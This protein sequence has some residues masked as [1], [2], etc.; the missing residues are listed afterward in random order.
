MRNQPRP[1]NVAEPHG[2]THAL[3]LPAADRAFRA[4]VKPRRAGGDGHQIVNGRFAPVR[5]VQFA[6][7]ED[8]VGSNYL[9]ANPDLWEAV[10]ESD[11]GAHYATTGRAQNRPYR[12]PFVLNFYK[13]LYLSASQ[14]RT[15]K[16]MEKDWRAA[17]DRYGSLHEVLF[18]AGFRPPNWLNYF[19]PD[20]YISY[21]YLWHSVRNATQALV[22]FITIGV[23][24]L[25]AISADLEFESAFVRATLGAPEGLDDAAL[26]KHWVEH[27]LGP[28]MRSQTFPPNETEMLRRLNLHLSFVPAS[29]DWRRYLAERPGIEGDVHDRWSAIEHFANAGVLQPHPLPLPIRLAEPLLRAAADRFAERNEFANGHAAYE[30]YLLCPNATGRGIQHAG[31]LALREGKFTR[32]LLLYNRVRTLGH[33]N[34]WTYVNGAACALEI[35]EFETARE[36]IF[37][38]LEDF[39]R[40][41]RLQKS[42]MDLQNSIFNLAVTRHVEILRAGGESTFAADVQEIYRSFQEC[43]AIQYGGEAALRRPGAAAKLVVAVLAN[44]DLAQCTYY[45][46]S[47]KLEHLTTAGV[48]IRVFPLGEEQKFLSAAATADVAIFYRIAA[49]AVTLQCAAYC[50]LINLPAIY[51]IDDLVFD[52][53]HF[54]DTHESYAGAISAEKHF[55]LRCGVALVRS[56]IAICDYGI[57]STDALRSEL[58]KLV[59]TGK[60]IVHRNLLSQEL[61][62]TASLGPK[63][64]TGSSVTIFYGSGTLAHGRDFHD[65][66]EPALFRLMTENLEVRFMACGHVD[67]TALETAFPSRVALVDFL[68][69]RDT[70]LKL[71]SGADINIAVL[72]ANRFNDCKSEIKWLEA[73]AFGIPSVVSDVAVYRENLRP[74]E[75]LLLAAADPA[76]WYKA[77]R[78]LVVGPALRAEIGARAR[79]RALELYEPKQAAKRLAASLGELAAQPAAASGQRRRRILIVNVFFPPQAI[80]GA[81]RIVA[82]QVADMCE[83]Y[84]GQYEVAVFCGN[85]EEAPPYEMTAYAWNGVPVYSVNTPLR[86]GND[87]SYADPEIRPAFESVLARFKPDLVHF[88][89]IQRLTTVMIDALQSRAIPFVVTVHDAWWISDHQFLID[90]RDR[91]ELPWERPATNS[92]SAVRLRML[93]AKLTQAQAVLAVSESF[94]ALYRRAGIPHVRALVNGMTGLPPLENAK[95]ERGKLRI[96]HF[97]GMGYIKGAFLLKRALSRGHFPDIE[98]VVVDLAKSY[99]EE[100]HEIWGATAVKIIG[101]VPQDKIGW[102]YG[103]IDVLIAPSVWPESFGLCVREAVTYGKWI[104]VSDRGALPEAV[105]PGVN[106][107]VVDLND[108]QALPA[109]LVKLQAQMPRFLQLPAAA[110]HIT[111][112]RENTTTLCGIFSEILAG[113]PVAKPKRRP[114]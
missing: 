27:M 57:A 77:L 112:M 13:E 37:E 67:V 104:V 84:A 41:A 45:R 30:R 64:F 54:P 47:Q 53:R 103:Q 93:A 114:H 5:Q 2:K 63:V 105:L 51:E 99:G 80:G 1:R 88:H 65:L 32:A 9:I 76:A 79:A 108:P 21:N 68:P 95:R 29:F 18:R 73:A 58:A 91:L 11:A 26:Y 12:L 89:A 23:K 34:L 86:E 78:A 19:V 20:S 3:K 16:Q 61:A 87:W 83:S 24:A 22:H 62:A 4:N 85:D 110:P 25:F 82:G 50:K 66:V 101:R 7:P 55:E 71:L 10:A 102:L 90:S 46:V 33:A 15:E 52:T 75:D 36:I 106:G 70:Y 107:F 49:S 39:P 109:I 92:A 97:G 113:T 8:F 48:E 28:H 35:R 6:L 69:D 44:C 38:G 40:N 60:V 56:F 100:S 31:D 94:A 42:F 98:L 81:T 111:T 43:Y 72:Q 14:N 17:G 96:G 74:D 59:K